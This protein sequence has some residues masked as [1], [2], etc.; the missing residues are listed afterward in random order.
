MVDHGIGSGNFMTTFTAVAATSLVAFE[1]E[2]VAVLT[3]IMAKR[4]GV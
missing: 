2:A 3:Y 4:L 1:M